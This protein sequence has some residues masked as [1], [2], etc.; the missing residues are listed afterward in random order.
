MD[1]F[2]PFEDA[3]E[4]DLFAPLEGMDEDSLRGLLLAA[5]SH[6]LSLPASCSFEPVKSQPIAV[7]VTTGCFSSHTTYHLPCSDTQNFQ[8]IHSFQVPVAQSLTL[9]DGVG[10]LA[11]EMERQAR[12]EPDGDGGVEMSNWGGF[13][14]HPVLFEDALDDESCRDLHALVS[15]AM[16]ELDGHWAA[17]GHKLYTGRQELRPLQGDL[18]PAYAWLNVNRGADLNYLHV[19]D[20]VLWSAVY[21]VDGGE[22]PSMKK[23]PPTDGNLVFRGGANMGASTGS[24][25]SDHA[26]HTYMAVPPTPGMLWVFPGSIPHAVTRGVPSPPHR[27]EPSLASAVRSLTQTHSSVLGAP[28]LLSL[29]RTHLMTVPSLAILCTR[30]HAA[31]LSRDQLHGR[32]GPRARYAS[33]QACSRT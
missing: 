33:I 16:D 23:E 32:S 11:L 12:Q 22:V 24:A 3:D 13:Q 1:V 30:R 9:N 10:A 21:F 15:A 7:P 29:G 28:T 19:H 25:I 6:A 17:L 14:S 31:H 2:A 18:H 27:G 5:R 20:P 4:E 26:S 8:T